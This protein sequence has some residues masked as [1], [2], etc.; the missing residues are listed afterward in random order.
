MRWPCLFYQNGTPLI[1][2]FSLLMSSFMYT[3]I[4]FYF[5][6]C[7]PRNWCLPTTISCFDNL[8]SYTIL[9]FFPLQ[10]FGFKWVPSKPNRDYPTKLW[11]REKTIFHCWNT[12][13]TKITIFHVLKVLL[14]FL[15]FLWINSSRY[16]VYSYLNK[17]WLPWLPPSS[18]AIHRQHLCSPRVL[19]EELISTLHN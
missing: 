11:N 17:E 14:F 7:P 18:Y 6:Y 12:V 3:F 19:Q 5:L 8:S 15:F 13:L 2:Q 16:H 4:R 10:S 9:C 1:F